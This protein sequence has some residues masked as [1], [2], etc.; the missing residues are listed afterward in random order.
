[1]P[2]LRGSGLNRVVKWLLLGHLFDAG[3]HR[4]EFRVD[5]RNRRSRAA[6]LKLGAIEEGVLRHHKITHTGFIRDTHVFAITGAEWARIEPALAKEVALIEPKLLEPKPL[7][8][9]L[10]G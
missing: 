6:V 2:R 1:V 3:T 8:P 4:V 5:A 7:E 9:K 10:A